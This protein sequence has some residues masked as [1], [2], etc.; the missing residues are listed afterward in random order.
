[1][2]T[3]PCPSMEELRLLGSS[4]QGTETFRRLEAH[5]EGCVACTD[6]LEMLASQGSDDSA[7]TSRKAVDVLPE[8]P[9]FV[10]VRKL[11]Q[12]G[13]GTVYEALQISIGRK[14]ALK[15]LSQDRLPP[16]AMRQRWLTEA[17]ALGQIRHPHVVR[18]L[19]AAEYESQ[20]YLVLELISGGTLKSRMTSPIPIRE[21]VRIVESIAR[22][23]DVLH[24]AGIVHLDIKPANILLDTS[25]SEDISQVIPLLSDFGIS[26]CSDETSPGSDRNFGGGPRG[27]PSYMAPEQI[28]A[29]SQ[30]IGKTT[31]VFALG[32]TL[33]ALLTGRPPFQAATTAGTLE[34]VRACSPISPR[35]LVPDLP[36]DLETICLVCLSREPS[37]RYAD[38]VQLADD[39]R[40]WLDGHVILA[41]SVS[42]LER[43]IRW[44]RRQPA[45]A[46]LVF[47]ASAATTATIIGLAWLWRQSEHHRLEAQAA[48]SRA[49]R[50]ESL[51]G[52]AVQQLLVLLPGMM[53]SAE[54]GI[55]E[56]SA[57]LLKTVTKLTAAIRQLP[58]VSNTHLIDVLKIQKQICEH[59]ERVGAEDE[60]RALLIDADQ[61]VEFHQDRLKSDPEVASMYVDLLY[62]SAYLHARHNQFGEL[63]RDLKRAEELLL[64]HSE[65]P[66]ILGSL[67]EWL[68]FQRDLAERVK[69]THPEF[70]A[71]ILETGRATIRRFLAKTSNESSRML[72]ASVTALDTQN[73][74]SVDQLS[75]ALR[76]FPTAL[77]HS[78]VVEGVFA[79]E[80]AEELCCRAVGQI[81][82]GQSPT[83]VAV[84]CFEQLNRHVD[85]THFRPELYSKAVVFLAQRSQV[86]ETIAR[87]AGNL[88]QSRAIVAW[89][90]QLG[91]ILR[92]HHPQTASPHYLLSK[93]FEHK[94][95]LAWTV[96][97][98][99]AA[100]DSL[101]S[102]L[103]E[104][105]L[106]SNLA[107][108][109]D[110]FQQHVARMRNKYLA[111]VSDIPEHNVT[112]K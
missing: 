4:R 39:L 64:L 84:D 80:L 110:V 54:T 12:G 85:T 92:E 86:Q 29:D 16:A 111:L 21:A 14:V 87:R 90:F 83:E 37:R 50:G 45:T 93:A 65:S 88:C 7:V 42:G 36:L 100:A 41:R 63:R 31:D 89:M 22:A 94:A 40:R 48:V 103:I 108:D 10:I 11:G 102:S 27:T 78:T 30:S 73:Q 18:L 28:A 76:L 8:I 107:P 96:S 47:A 79:G 5:V 60:W 13:A 26:Y 19:D 17:R 52:A 101:H 51:S 105:I 3:D 34:Q 82:E 75:K 20:M 69:T 38:A 98:A 59:F 68:G 35:D 1:M 44:H 97:D 99:K 67:F 112:A 53:N 56:K 70:S 62:R 15:L 24:R 95:K 2:A 33:Y 49:E 32:A 77:T 25:D 55:Y 9:G 66:V 72:L 74:R 81:A 104:A 109:E 57:E 61:L 43:L 23:V 58:A 6:L 91:E 106:A 71:E 46:A